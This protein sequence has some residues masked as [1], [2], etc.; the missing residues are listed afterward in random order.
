MK[1]F[2][3]AGYPPLENISSHQPAIPFFL[4]RCE[5]LD[6]QSFHVS[7]KGKALCISL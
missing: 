1:R 3:G 6:L 5:S 7:T 2:R 4:L